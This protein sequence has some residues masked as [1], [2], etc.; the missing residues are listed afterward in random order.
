M[1]PPALTADQSQRGDA[2][3]L[4]LHAPLGKVT[5]RNYLK[6]LKNLGNF[7]SVECI[8][9]TWTCDGIE[10]CEDGSDE[11]GLLCTKGL[12]RDED[13]L[14]DEHH[15]TGD[16]STVAGVGKGDSDRVP[17]ASFLRKVFKSK[18]QAI[19]LYQ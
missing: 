6:C 16:N 12:G 2:E 10:D 13:E 5:S 3:D 8:P 14:K 9:P 1:T 17:F 19:S 18:L 7:P 15:G 11:A 4:N